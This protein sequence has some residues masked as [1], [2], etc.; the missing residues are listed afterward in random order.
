MHLATFSSDA[1]FWLL[2]LAISVIIFF[3][4][5]VMGSYKMVIRSEVAKLK[6]KLVRIHWLPLHGRG[7]WLDAF[8][9]VTMVLPSG[10][11]VSAVCKCNIWDG[12]YWKS[13]P[14]QLKPAPA[15]EQ[16]P[17]SQPP[18]IVADCARCGYGIQQGWKACPNCGTAVAP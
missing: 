5:F 3:K 12:V 9:E 1:P 4:W 16:G 18:R 8:F 10:N 15:A 13:M 11:K 17:T 14:W 6:A 7:A 2:L